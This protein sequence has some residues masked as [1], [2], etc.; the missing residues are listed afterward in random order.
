[1][2]WLYS[3]PLLGTWHHLNPTSGTG[4]WE[5]PDTGDTF[6]FFLDE[7]ERLAEMVLSKTERLAPIVETLALEF[8]VHLVSE[9]GQ[10]SD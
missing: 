1:M 6:Y 4:I 3:V 9:T 7:D 10:P 8:D 2:D 5:E